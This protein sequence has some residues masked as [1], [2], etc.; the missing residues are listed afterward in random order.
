[1]KAPLVTCITPTF[2]RR[3]FL[4]RCISQFQAQTWPEKEMVIVDDGS[5]S[6]ADLVPADERIRYIRLD[7]RLLK[8]GA[9][10][11]LACEAARGELIAHWDDDDWMAPRRLTYQVGE[12]LH[13]GADL[14]GLQTVYYHN[15][16]AGKAWKIRGHGIEA[17]GTLLYKRTLWETYRFQEEYFACEDACFLNDVRSNPSFRELSLDDPG[18]Y[19]VT[20]HPGNTCSYP[21]PGEEHRSLLTPEDEKFLAALVAPQRF[22]ELVG[23]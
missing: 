6:I 8:I 13:S 16:E 21:T 9:K 10:R 20:V 17:G 12:L 5:D 2:N 3:Q 7:R 15:V 23:V 19:V 22:K 18:V 14:C 11:N 4:P 1:M